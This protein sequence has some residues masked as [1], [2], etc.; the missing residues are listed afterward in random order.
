MRVKGSVELHL[1]PPHVV[2]LHRM[3]MHVHP[4]Q[5]SGLQRQDLGAFCR[6]RE[7]DPAVANVEQP[8]RLLPPPTVSLLVLDTHLHEAYMCVCICTVRLL[9]LNAHLQA[10]RCMCMGVC[11]RMRICVCM[12]MRMCRCA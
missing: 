3:Y 10:D 2:G 7:S 1:Q 5:V 12:R 8:R 9:V 6:V 4:P 11:M